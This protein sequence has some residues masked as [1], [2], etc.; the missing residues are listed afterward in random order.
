VERRGGGEKIFVELFF[1]VGKNIVF[2]KKKIGFVFFCKKKKKKRGGG[3][4]DL[5]DIS[6]FD[7]VIIL[8]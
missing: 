8:F 5:I 1:P 2:F 4:V 7:A 6:Y 3:G